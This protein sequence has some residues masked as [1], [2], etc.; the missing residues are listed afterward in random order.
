MDSSSS[1]EIVKLACDFFIEDERES[2]LSKRI[3]LAS[4]LSDALT[5][6]SRLLKRTEK[7][8]EGYKNILTPT[9]IA[10]NHACGILKGYCQRDVQEN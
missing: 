6:N 2:H 9:P 3:K 1:D 10:A 5:D 7:L 8:A 4:D